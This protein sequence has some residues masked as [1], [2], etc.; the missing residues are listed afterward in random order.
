MHVTLP[1]ASEEGAS[2]DAFRS[3]LDKVEYKFCEDLMVNG[4]NDTSVSM[5]RILFL[6]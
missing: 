3:L 4:Y 5:L 2:S 1:R 6:P